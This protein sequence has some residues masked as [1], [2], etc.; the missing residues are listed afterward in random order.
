MNR[1]DKPGGYWISDDPA[2][3]QVDRVH[4]WLAEE[5]YWAKGRALDTTERAIAGSIN[6]GLYDAAGVQIGFCRWVTDGATFAWLCDVFVADT[7]RG[8]GLG[9]FLIEAATTHP[10]VSGLRMLL[11]T[12][13]A[14]GLYA[15]FGFTPVQA[16]DRLMEIW[17]GGP[18]PVS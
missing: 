2:L 5:S 12:G 7:A 11:G 14:H 17:K 4:Q 16:P 1:W 3:L 10:T 13:D 18:P 6:L 8:N 9:I 15:K